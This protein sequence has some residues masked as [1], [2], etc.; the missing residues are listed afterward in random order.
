MIAHKDRWEKDP[1]YVFTEWDLATAA[2]DSVLKELNITL[3]P[4]KGTAT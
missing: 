2:V 3:A 4:V 1:T